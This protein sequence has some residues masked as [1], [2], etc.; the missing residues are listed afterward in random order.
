MRIVALEEH[1]LV[2]S[3]VEEKFDPFTNPGF[4]AERR[5]KLGDLGEI[6]LKDMDAQGITQQVISAT[7]PGADL[8]N[9]PEG[10]RFAKAT[11]DRL[12][13]AVREHPTRF[14]GFAHLPMREPQAAADELERAI[15]DL[16][17]SG[18]MVNGLTD[19][20]F[21]D[22]LRFDPILARAAR[23]QVPIYIHPNI[24]PKAVFDIY[25]SGL[26]G[27]TG[28]L[29]GAGAFGWHSE[30]GIHVMRLALAGTFERHPNLTIIVG[31]MGEM[32]PFMLG[33]ADHVLK[34]NAGAAFATPV[35]S[36]AITDHVYITTAGI[37]TIPPFLNALTTFGADR[38][39]FSV[40]YPY[41]HNAVGR[42]FLD[43][44][45]V[46]PADREKIAHGN[47]DRVLKLKPTT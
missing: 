24:P 36:K 45:P 12:A 17:F 28:Q 25:Y 38:I 23:L 22:D 7:M 40:D 14:G 27:V 19:N 31:H 41:D 18:A 8:L 47:A 43:S 13:Q 1:F 5:H 11:N 15:R 6:R 4:T 26:P 46:S 20:R 21:L 37:F 2:P 29:L 10:I 16:G 42:A 33:R 32:L 35:V 44:L 30:V 3:L 9:G 34:L 39:M